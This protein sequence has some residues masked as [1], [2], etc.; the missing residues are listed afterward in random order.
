M[1]IYGCSENAGP[2]CLSTPTKSKTGAV[3]VAMPPTE[4]KILD[5]DRF[6]D[7]MNCK[8]QQFNLLCSDG[9]GEIC[10]RGRHIFMGYLKAPEKTKAVVTYDHWYR[11][12]DV[13]KIDSEGNCMLFVALEACL[14]VQFRI[15]VDNWSY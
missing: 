7:V 9:E 10:L 13:G 2:G 8:Q 4:L 15:P 6:V 1:N 11:T 5:P 12:G 14:F 3:G